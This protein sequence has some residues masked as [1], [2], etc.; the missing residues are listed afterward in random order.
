MFDISKY[1][2]EGLY[3]ITFKQSGVR[4]H[5]CPRCGY[6]FWRYSKHDKYGSV[7]YCSY[8]CALNSVNEERDK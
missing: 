1:F 6:G 4:K 2:Y 7:A 3:Y 5:Y 8:S